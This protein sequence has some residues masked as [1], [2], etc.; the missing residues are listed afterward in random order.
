MASTKRAR[1]RARKLA[2]DY[3]P[4]N[5]PYS[6]PASPTPEPMS[7]PGTAPAPAT[8]ELGMADDMGDGKPPADTMMDPGAGRNGQA[9][10]ARVGVHCFGCGAEDWVALAKVARIGEDGKVLRCILCRSTDLDVL[11]RDPRM[12]A[13]QRQA[14]QA[15]AASVW[16]EEVHRLEVYPG[17]TEDKL[18]YSTVVGDYE[19]IVVNSLGGWIWSVYG[20][21]TGTEVATGSTTSRAAAQTAAE[22]A[23]PT[24]TV[25]QMSMF[26]RLQARVA[27]LVTAKT[28]RCDVCGHTVRS[29][30][31]EQGW[32]CPVCHEGTMQDVAEK[33]AKLAAVID[34]GGDINELIGTG[35][36][37]EYVYVGPAE[38]GGMFWYVQ[39]DNLYAEGDCASLD[40]GQAAAEAALGGSATDQ[41]SLFAKR[42]FSEPPMDHLHAPS[43]EEIMA[44]VEAIPLPI[45]RLPPKQ[46]TE[47]AQVVGTV[48][49]TN[50]G[51]SLAQAWRLAHKAVM[52]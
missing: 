1:Q 12:S 2:N 16:S 27:K 19:L 46:Q 30:P 36:N 9:M 15:T 28:Q 45:K 3:A 5:N 40:E 23:V 47:A 29:A 8:T 6:A 4:A 10:A 49:S 7:S 25:G 18:I 44:K 37:G 48:L 13:H 39:G 42:A 22:A 50:P 34:W 51:L 26:A 32:E 35:P 17:L 38:E 41:M 14:M 11:D 31:D 24:E 33:E 21:A 20:T 43:V 52:G